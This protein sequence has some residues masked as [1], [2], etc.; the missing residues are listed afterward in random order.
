MATTDS[1]N[2]YRVV[3][4]LVDAGTEVLRKLFTKYALSSGATSIYQF[5]SNIQSQIFALQKKK[6]LKRHQLSLLLG[7]NPG[8]GIIDFDTWD[9]NLLCVLLKV[10]SHYGQQMIAFRCHRFEIY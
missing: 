10:M 5:M 2:F 4:L 9:I 3:S 7:Q 8:T 6:Y 1:E